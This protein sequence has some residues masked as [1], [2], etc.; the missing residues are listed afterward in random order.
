MGIRRLKKAV[1]EE[2]HV[3]QEFKGMT[4][5]VEGSWLRAG[6]LLKA[7]HQKVKKKGK[8]FLISLLTI[9]MLAKPLAAGTI[10]L[11]PRV[12]VLLGKLSANT[13]L[14]QD[15]AKEF[16]A[17]MKS[18]D[19]EVEDDL[20]NHRY[21]EAEKLLSIYL[22][23]AE[24]LGDGK[25]AKHL[26]VLLVDVRNEKGLYHH[27]QGVFKKDGAIYVAGQFKSDKKYIGK[28]KDQIETDALSRFR[29]YFFAKFALKKVLLHD[30]E[31]I[32]FTERDDGICEY[33]FRI[34]IVNDPDFTRQLVKK[35]PLFN[36]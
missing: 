29:R 13:I 15:A 28:V 17:I 36:F 18:I 4:S 26:R 3:L 31:I 1:K 14:V 11:L 9:L 8:R 33:L 6:T 23:I 24:Q 32:G 12:K 25:L 16:Q 10:D 34:G 21:D 5:T 20:K 22:Q 7:L 19:R 2:K 35:L 30:T 27:K